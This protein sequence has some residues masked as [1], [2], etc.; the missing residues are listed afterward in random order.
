M[1][2]CVGQ[3]DKAGGLKFI[4]GGEELIEGGRRR[5]AG[6]GEDLWVDP[7]PVD[8]VHVD[9]H[10][11]I[12]T[13]IRHD[14]GH[15]LGQQGIPLILF[16]HRIPVG[17]QTQRAPLLNIRPL[18][19]CG[20]RR[21]AGHGAGLQHSHG[22]LATTACHGEV[23]PGMAF[24][25]DQLLQGIGGALLTTGGPPVQHFDLTGEGRQGHQGDKRNGSGQASHSIH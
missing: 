15:L 2:S 20:S 14:F 18:D 11:H 13:L 24:V 19:L 21:V 25:F 8:P 16:G 6:L 3:G 4:G 5:G 1:P 10:R 12:V 22:C 23:F 17:E 9:R 7:Q